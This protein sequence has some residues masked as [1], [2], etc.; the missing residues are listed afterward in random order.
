MTVLMSADSLAAPLTAA[1]PAPDPRALDILLRA[2]N[3]FVD[4]GFDGASMQDL[5]RAAG[6]SVGNFYRYFPS[7]AALVAALITADLAEMD[8]DF[9]LIIGS[10][11]PMAALRRVI[12]GRVT[13][14]DC[15]DDGLLW[16][17]ITAA[18]LRTPEIA[19]ITRHMDQRIVGYLCAVFARVTGATPAMAEALHSARAR[20]LVALVKT[21]GMLAPD[22]PTTPAVRIHIMTAIDRTLSEIVALPKD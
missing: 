8:R 19:A 14:A 20:F 7:K 18:A 12:E 16:A 3:A 13:G 10:D 5:A 1:L 15:Q 6:M 22:D 2:R 4:K 21:A 9:A 11:E 17:E